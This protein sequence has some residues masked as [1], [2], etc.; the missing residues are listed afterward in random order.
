MR[1]H[2]HTTLESEILPCYPKA[3]YIKM[4][5]AMTPVSRVCFIIF[6]GAVELEG[7]E[8]VLLAM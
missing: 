2:I 7:K 5:D 6:F 4:L 1:G 3:S 8:W